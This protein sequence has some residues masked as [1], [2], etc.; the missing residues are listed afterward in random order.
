M[1]GD[2]GPWDGRARGTALNNGGGRTPSGA[3]W[4][5][6]RKRRVPKIR[7]AARSATII[8]GA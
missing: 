7:S 5:F 1:D 3:I 4:R 6:S 8:T 2:V